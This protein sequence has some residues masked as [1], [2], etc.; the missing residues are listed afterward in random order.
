MHKVETVKDQLML[1]DRHLPMHNKVKVLLVEVLDMENLLV[2]MQQYHKLV[3]VQVLQHILVIQTQ[4]VLLIYL[5][6]QLLKQMELM[7]KV[8]LV[9]LV[10]LVLQIM[11]YLLIISVIME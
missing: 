7:F 1:L 4:L 9:L 6:V 3:Q 11:E 5:W 8:L 10:Y 2:L